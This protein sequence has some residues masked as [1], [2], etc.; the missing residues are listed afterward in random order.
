MLGNIVGGLIVLLLAVTLI[1]QIAQEVDNAVNCNQTLILNESAPLGK[2]DSFGGGGVGQF[3]GYDGEL[4]KSWSSDFAIVKSNESM[5]FNPECKP[6]EGAAATMVG[7]ITLFFVLGGMIVALG[8]IMSG[9]R[10]S[11]MI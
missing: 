9:L 11:E 8:I 7:L 2:T 1:P 5:L 10:G 6:L 3:G 4:K